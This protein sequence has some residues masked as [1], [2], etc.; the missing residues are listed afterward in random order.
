MR[1]VAE[2]DSMTARVS[3]TRRLLIFPYVLMVTAWMFD[4][5][6]KGAGQGLA[7]QIF[8]LL[9]YGGFF[10]IFLWLDRALRIKITGFAPLL[11]CTFIYLAVSIT[12]GLQRGQ[13]P[14]LVFRHVLTILIYLTATY[15]TA[16]MVVISSISVLRGALGVL[17]L[18]FA[19]S[20]FFIVLFFQGGVDLS[21]IRYQIQGTSSTAALGLIVLT[22]VFSL[23]RIEKVAALSAAIVIFLSITRSFLVV[24]AVQG[25]VLLPIRQ[26]LMRQRFIIA[27]VLAGFI[28]ALFLIFG[29]ESA[30][31]WVQRLTVIEQFGGIDPTV[32]TRYVEWE[33]MWDEFWSSIDKFLFGS[34]LAAETYYWIAPELGG[35]ADG[36]G[37]I[38]FG[39]NQHL[40]LLFNAGLVGGAPLLCLQFLQGWQGFRFLLRAR[41]YSQ[42][43]ADLVFLGAWGVT[44]IFGTLA[45]NFLFATFGSRGFTLWY[46]IGTGLLLGA[47][48]WMMPKGGLKVSNDRM[49]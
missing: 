30:E 33:Y 11:F 27:F 41:Q 18:G 36:F 32:L 1:T 2:I 24:F 34:G 46:G 21:T 14:Y 23:S 12:S 16:R 39:H 42:V 4:F 37:S 35:R 22:F 45:G 6:S 20:A 29:G 25:F 44:I 10:T 15:A 17:C 26:R 38:G 40:S 28:G 31:R 19:V 13:D 3:R 49:S 47:R 9:G 48:T 5:Q 8:F 43:K 7:I